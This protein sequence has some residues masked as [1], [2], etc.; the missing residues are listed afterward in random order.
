[1][2]VVGIATIVLFMLALGALEMLAARAVPESFG[3]AGVSQ[4]WRK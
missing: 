3:A 2:R 1:V 4:E